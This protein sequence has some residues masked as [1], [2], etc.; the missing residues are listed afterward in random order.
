MTTKNLGPAVSGYLD[1]DG[2]SFENPVFQAGKP[3]L[4][5]ELNLAEDLA[6][7][8]SLGHLRKSSPSG[9]LSNDFLNVTDPSSGVFATNNTANTLKIPSQVALVNGWVI[10]VL[11]TNTNTAANILNLGAGPA[12]SG[13]KRTDLV[14]L[15]V[16]RRLI[17]AS[18]STV[19]KS[20]T[21][22]I[23]ENGNVKI[24]SSDDVAL[25]FADD[26]LDGVV[27]SE[28]TKRVQVQYRLRVISGVDLFAYPS[29]IDDPV[30]VANSVPAS[31]GSPD[32]V[33]TAF[34]YQN[35]SANGDPGLW[36]AGDG[37]PTN[38]LGTVDGYMYAIPLLAVFR[39]NTTA[40]NRNSNHNGGVA[41]PGP[42]DRPD[43]LF[44]DIFALRDI[45]DLRRGV[46]LQGISDFG[47]ILEKNF[48]ALLDNGLK[49]EWGITANGGGLAGHTVL[50]ADEI[51]LLPGDGVTTGDT[52]GAQ[53]VG[54]FDATRR[55]FS[56][57]PVYEVIT[58]EVVPGTASV[59]TSTWQNGT[60]VT[61][62]PAAISPYP[63]TAFNFASRAPSGIRIVDVLRTCIQG[64][65]GQQ[66]VEVGEAVNTA[67]PVYPIVSITG[68]SENPPGVVVLTLGAV[69]GVGITTE[70]MYV[71]LLVAYPPG[72]GLAKTPTGDYGSASFTVNNPV[73]LPVGAPISFAAMANQNLDYAHREVQ[74]Q[75]TTSSITYTFAAY[76]G[77][78]STSYRL[79]ERAQSLVQVTVNGVSDGGVTLS[80]SGR[81]ITLSA[82]TSPGDVVS[83]TYSGLRPIPQGGPQMTIYYETRMPQTISSGNLGTNV[84]LIPR[85][86]SPYL[87]VM[88]SGPSS[89]GDLY[90]FPYAYAQTG[91][92]SIG[93]G[94]WG[95]EYLLGGEVDVTLADFSASTGM[96]RVPVLIPYVPSPDQVSFQR[97]SGNVDIEGRSFFPTVPLTYIPSAYGPPL[98][99][100]RR[101]KVILPMLAEVPGDLPFAKKGTLVLVLI[102]RWANFDTEN[103]VHF[104]PVTPTNN[105]TTASI[106]RIFGSLLNRKA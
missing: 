15:E 101:H 94:S 10:P 55:F 85:W 50:W 4:D 26:I 18:P 79:P 38:T 52:P 98:A 25:N 41:S 72:N 59:S 34:T 69:P 83:V 62:D 68:L 58:V 95:G 57:R 74:L 51:G 97:V 24:Q 82:L 17:S 88:V 70:P 103:G 7:S 29:G 53:F 78:L 21:A 9:W 47:E 42:S 54:Q 1:P 23:W 87:Y 43:G 105:N 64:A 22:R 45:A 56:S 104:D 81:D 49:T 6:N 60:Q 99:D 27:N 77:N 39:R 16:W 28:T 106:F 63:Y 36:R 13:V 19:G 91:G 3:V 65:S 71:D 35:Q 96:L 89:N 37:V 61:L 40:F 8:F 86:I 67:G 66:T 75:Y 44:H 92:I 2:R 80:S 48:N 76:S 102:T 5:K 20:Q 93:V 84:P 100:A 33:G 90:P 12:G 11:H 46:S 73:A 32:G 31:A 14:I 30:A